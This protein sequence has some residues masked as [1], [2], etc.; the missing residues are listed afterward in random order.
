[1]SQPQKNW[2]KRLN[3]IRARYR[4]MKRDSGEDIARNAN[5]RMPVGTV[6][7]ETMFL[8]GVIDNLMGSAA[9]AEEPVEDEAE[10]TADV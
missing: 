3:S 1:M 4:E 7:G 6:Y 9:P 2:Q 10:E 5:V 8:I